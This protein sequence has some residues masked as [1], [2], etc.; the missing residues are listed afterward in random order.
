[1]D[2]ARF[3]RAH[4][5]DAEYCAGLCGATR[6]M[7]NGAQRQRDESAPGPGHGTTGFFSPPPG[8]GKPVRFPSLAPQH[9]RDEMLRNW[10]KQR[11]RLSL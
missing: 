10:H 3:E 11:G 2:H 7:T 8:S 5:S 1:M 6:P 4:F 9:G